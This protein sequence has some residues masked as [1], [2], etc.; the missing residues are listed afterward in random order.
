[1]L[2]NTQLYL[3]L[4]KLIGEPFDSFTAINDFIYDL[5][6][7]NI[8][9][10]FVKLI[11]ALDNGP[12]YQYIGHYDSKKINIYVLDDGIEHKVV[13]IS[14]EGVGSIFIDENIKNIL[15]VT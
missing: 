3:E 12:I 14:I 9:L 11:A 5:V 1:M 13:S 6:K 2:D 4:D 7:I 8:D 15:K 10:K